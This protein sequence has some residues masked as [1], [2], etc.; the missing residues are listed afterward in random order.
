M[1]KMSA[2]GLMAMVLVAMIASMVFVCSASA[3]YQ[4][5]LKLTSANEDTRMN[6]QDL[7]FLLVT[8]NYDAI[9]KGD[10]VEVKIND[11]VYRLTPNGG[12]A[13]LA[14]IVPQ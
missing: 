7:A 1:R 6:A 4:D 9:P 14:D 13:G 12:K 3:D 11:L 8:H 2:F 5:L 10:H